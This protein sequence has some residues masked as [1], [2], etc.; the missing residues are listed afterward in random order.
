MGK[1]TWQSIP[2]KF[3][4]LSG[5]V[6]IILST[7]LTDVPNDVYVVKSM[8]EALDVVNSMASPVEE[9]FVIGGASVY[10][11][12]CLVLILAGFNLTSVFKDFEC[13]TF[14][15]QID[16]DD[17]TRVPNPSNVPEKE[18]EENGIKFKISVYEKC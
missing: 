7:T 2:A 9:V 18:F 17:F 13:D 3:R 5:R 16:E 10:K 6:N 11:R 15:P 8:E 12:P 1:N 4:P 14:L